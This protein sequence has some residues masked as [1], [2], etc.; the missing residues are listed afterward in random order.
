MFSKV[1]LKGATIYE[2][3]ILQILDDV[4]LNII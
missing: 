2:L 3:V 4:R 1:I